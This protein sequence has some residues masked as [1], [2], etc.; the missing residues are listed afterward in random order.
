MTFMVRKAMT[1][2]GQ[3]FASR[4]IVSRETMDTFPPLLRRRLVEQRRV[5][6]HVAKTAAD[7]GTVTATE[8]VEVGV[9]D[10]RCSADTKSGARCKRDSTGEDGLCAIHHR[11]VSA[12]SN[13]SAEG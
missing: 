11:V 9:A 6:P 5:V 4:S 1:V 10:V 3:H 12:T 7:A 13:A 2:Q 8:V